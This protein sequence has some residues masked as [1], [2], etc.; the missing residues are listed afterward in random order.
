MKK[1]ILIAPLA[2]ALGACTVNKNAL[3][4][5]SGAVPGNVEDATLIAI[6]SDTAAH[7]TDLLD[8]Q[9]FAIAVLPD[10]CLV[11]IGDNGV[12]GYADTRY[13]P[14]TGDP[15]CTKRLPVGA[16]ISEYRQTNLPDLLP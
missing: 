1:L 4:D 2:L 9:H 13:D 14:V 15:M 8:D 11:W 3:N 5:Y 6:A 12:E 16:V 10:G 7:N